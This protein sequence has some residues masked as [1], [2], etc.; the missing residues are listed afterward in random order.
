MAALRPACVSDRVDFGVCGR[1]AVRHDPVFSFTQHATVQDHDGPKWPTSLVDGFAG[2]L[3]RSTQMDVR[4][5]AD[6]VPHAMVWTMPPSTRS[7]APLV[8][9]ASFEAT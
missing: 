9:E 8:A 1:V 4:H 6:P 7:A 3:D 2:K 5:L